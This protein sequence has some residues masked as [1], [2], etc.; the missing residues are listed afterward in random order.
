VCFNGLELS[1]ATFAHSCEWLHIPHSSARLE[2]EQSTIPLPR[3]IAHSSHSSRSDSKRLSQ[4]LKSKNLVKNGIVHSELCSLRVVVGVAIVGWK[5]GK[6]VSRAET[7]QFL[8]SQCWGR[9]A[10]EAVR[11]LSLKSGW[12][13]NRSRS[14]SVPMRPFCVFALSTSSLSSISGSLRFK[15]VM[16]GLCNRRRSL[17]ISLGSE[18][19]VP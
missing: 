11:T 13:S 5:N 2:R 10:N 17:E 8:K 19:S 16:S 6:R 14:P 18:R 15:H 7:S 4:K 12:R 3:H 1:T 9:S